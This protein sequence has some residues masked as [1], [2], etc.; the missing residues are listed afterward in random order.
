MRTQ[1]SYLK[2]D[3]ATE[4]EKGLKQNHSP[5]GAQFEI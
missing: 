3:N 1:L 5:Q 2:I 4:V